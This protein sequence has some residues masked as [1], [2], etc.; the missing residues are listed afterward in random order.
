MQLLIL[1]SPNKVKDVQRYTEQLGQP[2]LVK[3]TC[4]HILDLP[5]MAR[6]ACVDLKTFAPTELVP[7]DAAGFDRI[8]HL[9][10]AI[11]QATKVIVATDPD[12]EGE[13]IA[14]E[15]WP[16]IP[17][18][19][20]FRATFEEI[21]LRGV[22]HGLNNM[23]PS[24]NRSAADAAAARRIIDRLAGWHATSVVFEKLRH[25]KGVSAGRLQ[26]AT[27]RLVVD[28]YRETQQFKPTST[29]GIRLKLRSPTGQ[30]F[31]A[32]LLDSDNSQ[33]IFPT[34][35]EASA[36]AHP[37]SAAVASVDAAKKD[38]KPRPPF[39]A[40][41]W[42]QVAQKALHLNVKDASAAIQGLF[43][44]GQTTYPRTDT[45]R[46][47]IDAIEWARA[48][49]LR[50]F[51]PQYLPPTPIE[52]K[53]R[54]PSQGAHEAIRPTIP[55]QSFELDAR[56]TGSWSAA[57][58][59]IEA[60]FLASQA[61]S[62]IVEQTK[63]I[64]SADGSSYEVSGQVEIFDGWK[65]VL[66]TDAQ[67]EPEKPEQGRALDEEQDALPPLK[68]GDQLSIVGLE[69][70][71][72]TTKPKPSFT[73]AGLVAELKRLGIGRPSTYPTIVPLLLSRGWVT[74]HAPPA[75]AKRKKKAADG[76]SILVPEPVALELADFLATAFPSL[77][78]YSFT[79][80]MEDQLDQIDSQ[81]NSRLDVSAAWW[82]R[83]EQ[84]LSTARGIKARTQER[85][86]LGPC[87]KCQSDGRA[88]RL[89]LIKGSKDDRAFEFAACDQD[90]KENHSCG[91]TS[92][93]ENGALIQLL[94]CP[95]CSSL[96]RPVRRRDGGHSWVCSA[97][98]DTKWFLADSN[99]KIVRSPVCPKCSNPMTHRERSD[100]KGD[101]FWGCYSCH[102]FTD[103]DV[104]GAI[105]RS[106]GKARHSTR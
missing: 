15:I 74:E 88:G 106:S 26:S 87:P 47:S 72:I 53:D 2:C 14:A 67:E 105:I 55:H 68:P 82:R 95:A 70:I 32:R 39:E 101:F 57:Y 28:R 80:A 34:Q 60:R 66:S 19:K 3:A 96:M 85:P 16:W 45:V 103:A 41:S 97:C 37:K 50:R 35:A 83:F 48:E 102:S 8:A 31:A 52:H 73:Q 22:E 44:Q 13:A 76:L 63:V 93:T 58:A 33:R 71:T 98:P 36:F 25:L 104:F 100:H 24:L 1:E 43:E 5:P 49:I 21:T 94:K 89:R 78:D 99:W 69:I 29:Y 79:A 64:I 30:E 62:R 42:L 23:S 9:K 90:S 18:S 65:R 17:P 92:Q 7:R 86:D 6:G 54:G 84:E 20:A 81:K 91:F 51:G 12:R 10:Q 11:T 59:L 61:A 77:V 56:R 46:V 4:G 27:L 38:Q 40:T 75:Q